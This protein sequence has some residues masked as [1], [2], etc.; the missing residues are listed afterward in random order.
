MRKCKFIFLIIFCSLI[1]ISSLAQNKGKIYGWV[2]DYGTREPIPNVNVTIIGTNIGTTTDSSGYFKFELNSGKTYSINFSYIGYATATRII[3]LEKNEE[4][5]YNILLKRV[6]IKLPPVVKISKFG[7]IPS[8]FTFNND[9]L[10]KAG[11]N[12]LEKALVYL[13]P[14]ILYP[15]WFRN[16]NSLKKNLYNAFY[17][18][19]TLY[20]NGKLVDSS[21]L[22]E[23]SID[24]IKFV[25]VWMAWEPKNTY[26]KV[27]IAPVDMPL[28]EG[29]YVLLIVT[30]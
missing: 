22:D 18:N 6:P 25:K 10:K 27:D 12:D 30:K 19:F 20:V 9:E 21:T 23:I 16:R 15:D 2:Y 28:V 8:T 11:D 7:N 26:G 24:K 1:S 13:E 17:H 4:I 29:N 14:I 5:E 3:F